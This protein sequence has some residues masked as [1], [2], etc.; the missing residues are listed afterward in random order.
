MD[1]KA[2]PRRRG[3][4]RPRTTPTNPHTQLEESPGRGIVEELAR[5][6]FALPNEEE[7]PSGISMPGAKTP[8][9]GM[10][11]PAGR[12]APSKTLVD[13]GSRDSARVVLGEF[14]EAPRLAHGDVRHATPNAGCVPNLSNRI[15]SERLREF[16]AP[17]KSSS[18]WV[19]SEWPLR[20]G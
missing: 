14:L 15:L 1:R 9:I 7:R 6:A 8:C 4:S 20:V 16:E 17:R 11:H 13:A 19:V 3:G 10:D 12:P 5:R 18:A 2:L